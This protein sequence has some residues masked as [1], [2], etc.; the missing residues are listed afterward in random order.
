MLL[1]RT[2]PWSPKANWQIDTS[3]SGSSSTSSR[4]VVINSASP[5][6]P[7]KAN[8]CSWIVMP[9]SRARRAPS[10]GAEPGW[11]SVMW[12]AAAEQMVQVSRSRTPRWACLSTMT[13]WMSVLAKSPLLVRVLLQKMQLLYRSFFSR[14]KT[15][16]M[17]LQKLEATM[18]WHWRVEAEWCLWRI[19]EHLR[20]IKGI[21]ACSRSLP[22]VGKAFSLRSSRIP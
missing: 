20:S 4:M 1:H 17:H 9:A 19:K 8:S 10:S 5:A 7:Q 11:A 16:N 12:P 13:S 15:I 3:L 21:T 2:S 6:T 14:R 22:V 18:T